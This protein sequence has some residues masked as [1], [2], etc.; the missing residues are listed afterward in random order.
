MTGILYSV[1]V[2]AG[3]VAKELEI[4]RDAIHMEFFV[5]DRRDCI[6]AIQGLV[7]DRENFGKLETG[8]VG[9]I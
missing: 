3:V 1:Q 8:R 7:D 4:R 2:F 9:C 6:A 5:V